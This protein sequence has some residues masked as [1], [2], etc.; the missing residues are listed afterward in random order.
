MSGYRGW[1]EASAGPARCGLVGGGA[2][3][4]VRVRLFDEGAEDPH[5]E[6]YCD[7]R[8]DEALRL[9]RQ[10]LAAIDDAERHT[11]EAGYWRTG[12]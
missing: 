11:R 9:A 12:R 10:L 1:A 3:L 5:P 8:P 7:L 2:H 6:A 4:L